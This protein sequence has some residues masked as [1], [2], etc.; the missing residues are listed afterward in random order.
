MSR[1]TKLLGEVLNAACGGPEGVASKDGGHKNPAG[2]ANPERKAR[3]ARR[4]GCAFFWLLF[5][6]QAK[7]SNS[8]KERKLWTLILLLLLKLL[9]LRLTAFAFALV[10]VFTVY[11]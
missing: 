9:I 7:K 10:G 5:F 1:T 8:L 3:R 2:G 11:Q 4:P 6:A